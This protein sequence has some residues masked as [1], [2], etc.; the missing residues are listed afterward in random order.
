VEE[1]IGKTETGNRYID[2][3]ARVVA[4]AA[5]TEVLGKQFGIFIE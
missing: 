5:Y 4:K 1:V 3:L 2:G